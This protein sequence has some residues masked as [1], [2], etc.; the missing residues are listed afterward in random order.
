MTAAL[1][2]GD[3]CK[4]LAR[5]VVPQLADLC[6]VD[7][8]DRPGAG[9][10]RRLAAAVREPSDEPLL[11]RLSRVRSYRV[12]SPSDG[13]G[14]GGRRAD[15]PEAGV[16]RYPDNPEAAAAYDRLRLRSAIVVPV[17]ARGRVLGSLTLYT[18]HPYGRR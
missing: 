1:D 13:R 10:A 9:V 18:Q 6:A 12:G 3:A 14:A 11:Q 15:L 16:E 8:L 7:L 4:R 2:V 17:G 5:I